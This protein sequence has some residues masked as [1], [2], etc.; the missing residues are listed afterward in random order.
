[1]DQY[2]YSIP[3]GYP[4]AGNAPEK[5]VNISD[6]TTVPGQ[7]P[8]YMNSDTAETASFGFDAAAHPQ[9]QQQ[10]QIFQP[11][12]VP[13][14]A[15]QTNGQMPAETP[16]GFSPFDNQA[17]FTSQ[18][19]P[20]PV[21]PIGATISPPSGME[22][23]YDQQSYDPPGKVSQSGMAPP[24]LDLIQEVSTV[25]PVEQSLGNAVSNESSTTPEVIQDN[26]GSIPNVVEE[27]STVSTQS[28]ETPTS[29]APVSINPSDSQ[30][31]AESNQVDPATENLSNASEEPSAAAT[32]NA[33][34]S[35]SPPT[36]DNLPL[37][38][39]ESTVVPEQPEDAS[40]DA[41]LPAKSRSPTPLCKFRESTQNICSTS[42][43]KKRRRIVTLNDDDDSDDEDV[44]NRLELL[45]SPEPPAEGNDADGTSS[46]AV[47][48]LSTTGDKRNNGDGT[49]REDDDR[50]DSAASGAASIF[51]N[52]V[53]IPAGDS[54]HHKRKKIRVLDS[55]DDEDEQ[56]VVDT[57]DDIGLT[58]EGADELNPG[59]LLVDENAEDADFGTVDGIELENVEQIVAMDAPI[60]DPSEMTNEDDEDGG[61]DKGEKEKEASDR[62]QDGSG[63]EEEQE[64]DELGEEEEVV[65]EGVEM[66][67]AEDDEGE[68]IG[69]AT[70]DEQV[71]GDDEQ[72]EADSGGEQEDDNR[73]SDE[74]EQQASDEERSEESENEQQDE[75]ESEKEDDRQEEEETQNDQSDT[76][77][78][79]SPVEQEKDRREST[80]KRRKKSEND[81][82]SDS[83]DDVVCQNDL[84][85]NTIS[86]LTDEEDDNPTPLPPPKK[87]LPVVRIVNIKK[88]VLDDRTVK[89]ESNARMDAA[90]S[91]QQQHYLKKQH[92]LAQKK[93]EKEKKRKE[94]T[95]DNNDPFGAWSSSS[96]EDEFIPNDIY[97]GTPD[98][99]FTASTKTR[100][101]RQ[102][103]IND[104][105]T[106]HGKSG[107]PNKRKYGD[108]SD[109]EERRKRKQKLDEI[110]RLNLPTYQQQQLQ[111][112]VKKKKKRKNDRFYDKSQD[113]PNDIYFGNVNVPLHILYGF[114]D[115]SSDDEKRDRRGGNIWKSPPPTSSRSGKYHSNSKSF[116]SSSSSSHRSS[117]SPSSDR[118]VQAMKEYLK[119]AGFKSVKFHKLWEG[120][121]SNQERAN[122]IL[123]LMQEKGLEGEPTIAKCRELRKQLQM[124]REAQ[125]LDTSLIIDSG[126]GRITRRSAR[127]PQNH[128][129]S[130]GDP[131]APSTSGLSQPPTVT[132]E[133]LETLNRIRNVIDPDSDGEE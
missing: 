79:S 13:I 100:C 117:V 15:G 128:Q 8:Y 60:I 53:M 40:H 73:G 30:E 102:K 124:E 14:P 21:L 5:N 7:N 11:N 70:D 39:D 27:T 77:S 104:R 91:Y 63:A 93:R 71:L 48:E 83:E 126:E 80:S 35:E 119:I 107:R 99:V 101:Q 115:S 95:F 88:E 122:A 129:L 3:P 61:S 94:R 89:R 85:L 75:S 108:D 74:E 58:G 123:R 45:R 96:S 103:M 69:I 32:A 42:T 64:E 110:S 67:T 131:N 78:T 20:A 22:G 49:E 29:E 55:D 106:K 50:P 82:N 31:I 26:A 43:K 28:V 111:N 10:Q 2:P 114:G 17:T 1:M 6:G 59:G 65:E 98:R 12:T 133:S 66:I 52:V 90:T 121:K 127:N 87:E 16:V 81:K 41:Y 112:L 68:A 84:E 125:V 132:P 97:F 9:Q 109:V 92:Q 33:D 23:M 19:P 57:V 56:R 18:L 72:Q 62:E 4:Y 47:P 113:I 36:E 76:R 86:L 34:T 24:S 116:K 118:S 37:A 25:A 130:P 54:D 46:G 38:S 120:C 44:S 105:Y 51:Q